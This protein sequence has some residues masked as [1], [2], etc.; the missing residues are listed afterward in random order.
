MKRSR[1][2]ALRN[3]K[4]A[5]IR[6]ESNEIDTEEQDVLF[7]DLFNSKNLFCK[8]AMLLKSILL[9]S[10]I[11]K[12]FSIRYAGKGYSSRKKKQINLEQK[13]IQDEITEKQNQNLKPRNFKRLHMVQATNKSTAKYYSEILE[14]MKKL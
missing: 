3:S 1:S 9:S 13:K 6:F 12:C 5:A 2:F 14:Q 10:M 11:V 7:Q 4:K 8:K